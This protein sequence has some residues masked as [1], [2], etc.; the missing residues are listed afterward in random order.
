[1]MAEER[2]GKYHAVFRARVASVDRERG[3]VVLELVECR[4]PG[5]I[6]SVLGE[7]V[8]VTLAADAAKE[9]SAE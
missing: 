7:T 4:P 3:E 1:M 8:W 5:I 2:R 6:E 9:G